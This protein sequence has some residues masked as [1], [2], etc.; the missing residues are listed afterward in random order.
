MC[1]HTQ[2]LSTELS[3]RTLFLHAFWNYIHLRRNVLLCLT[4]LLTVL[5]C[6]AEPLTVLR[7][8]AEPLTVLRCLAEPL[9][10]L[11]YAVF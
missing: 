8:L 11:R 1:V 7:C 5:H 2:N 3:L 9:T 4:E 10:V 6:L